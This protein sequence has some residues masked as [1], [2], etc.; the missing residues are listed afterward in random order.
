MKLRGSY[1][2]FSRGN[3]RHI[4]TGPAR[5]GRGPGFRPAAG[6][7]VSAEGQR[8]LEEQFP[9][10]PFPADAEF[11][12]KGEAERE[13]G[14]DSF[15]A[16][17]DAPRG[18]SAGAGSQKVPYLEAAQKEA[19]AQ[20]VDVSLILAVIKKESSFNPNAYNKSGAT[21]LMQVLPSTA[22]W[23][24]LKDTKQLKTP[25]VNIKYGVKY[26]KYLHGQFGEGSLAELGPEDMQGEGLQK[27]LAAYNAG[28]GNVRKYDGIPPFPETRTYVKKVVGFFSDFENMAF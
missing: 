4:D 12:V 24:G 17:A 13:Y 26:L 6:P 25:A 5:S 7:Q 16:E 23:L 28:P 3:I 9:Q 10:T 21:G 1:A 22:K 19:A 20:G 15:A 11:L 14:E 2:H 27:T 8:E 18:K